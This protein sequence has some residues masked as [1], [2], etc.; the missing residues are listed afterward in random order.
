MSAR[1][2]ETDI[3]FLQRVLKVSGLYGGP[4]DGK[5]SDGVDEAED[6]L[7]AKYEEIKNQLG[8]FDQRSE[9]CI[10]T[11]L[12][13]AQVKAREFMRVANGFSLSCKIISGTR[14]YA[15]QDNLFKVGRTVELDRGKVTNARGGQSNHNFAIAW[16]VGI[17]DNGRYLEGK[18]KEEDQAYADLATLIAAKVSGLE[19]GGSW[20]SIHDAP[21]YQLATGKSETEIRN[22]FESGKPYI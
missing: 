22:L 16:D 3:L 21:H 5:W 15:E 8:A 9:A 17:F 4:L 10:K 6:A 20:V 14:T 2:F 7:S 19:W 12:P 11:L 18:T 13:G 1:L